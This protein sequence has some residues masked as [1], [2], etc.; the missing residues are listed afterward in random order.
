MCEYLSATPS[1]AGNGMEV[2][3]L[4]GALCSGCTLTGSAGN[5]DAMLNIKHT[6][7]AQLATLAARS[8]H[9][10]PWHYSAE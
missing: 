2:T 5:T 8:R 4:G 6:Q 9:A 3:F 10:L 1:D 7:Y